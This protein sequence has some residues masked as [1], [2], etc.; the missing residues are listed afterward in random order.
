MAD[1]PSD[2]RD[3]VN[4]ISN[5]SYTKLKLKYE[6]LQKKIKELEGEVAWYQE[7]TG[8]C[9]FLFYSST[10]LWLQDGASTSESST[11]HSIETSKSG[12]VRGGYYYFSVGTN[13][14]LNTYSFI[15]MW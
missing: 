13:C 11:S 1:R 7:I 3:W 10:F 12:N 5:S 4:A 2:A 15:W 6:R 8:F 9:I 14:Y